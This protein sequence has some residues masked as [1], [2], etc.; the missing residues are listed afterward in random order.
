MLYVGDIGPPGPKGDTGDKGPRGDS[1][2]RGPRG[3]T[4]DNNLLVIIH[5]SMKTFQICHV[6]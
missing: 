2:S 1:G 6:K 5:I 4:G 3:N